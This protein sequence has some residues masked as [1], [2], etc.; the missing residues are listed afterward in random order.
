MVQKDYFETYVE[1]LLAR[2]EAS[3]K[4]AREQG[5]PIKARQLD[6]TAETLK[7]DLADYQKAKQ[8]GD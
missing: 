6:A 1:D 4:E 2:L 3:A 7:K 5:F 8:D